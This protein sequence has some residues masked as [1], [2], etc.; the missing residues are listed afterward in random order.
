MND[1]FTNTTIL[2][3]YL[4]GE[5]EGEALQSIREKIASDDQFAAEL[6]SLRLAKETV[7]TYGLK[8]TIGSIHTEMMKELL[9]V[10]APRNI[11]ISRIMQYSMRIA[12][13]L[14]IALSITALYQYYSATPEKLY[15]NEYETFQLHETRGSSASL[16]EEPYKKADLAAVMT[17]FKTLKDPQ[18]EDYFLNGNAAL[19]INNSPAAISS[20]LA[21]QEKNKQANTHFFEEDTDYYLGLAYLHNNEP[22]KALPLFE[23]IQADEGH[24]YHRNVSAWFLRKLKRLSRG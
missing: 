14:L 24:A 7:K 23:K 12:A 19:A 9:T 11:G 6:E 17:V 1:N 2:I 22:S 13:T 3:Q 15:E 21:L 5:L 16:L 8:K 4:D 10:P 20:F 18:A